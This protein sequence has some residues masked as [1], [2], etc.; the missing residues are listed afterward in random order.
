MRVLK[1]VNNKLFIIAETSGTTYMD[2]MIYG[3]QTA[4][5][6]ALFI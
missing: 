2:H 3:L 5:P 4:Q 1:T 6:L